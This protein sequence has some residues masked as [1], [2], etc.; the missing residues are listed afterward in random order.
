MKT[1]IQRNHTADTLKGLAV[2][3]M[4]QVHII[5]QF[6]SIA[7]N[8]SMYG[9]ISY[10][11]GGPFCAPVFIAVMGYFLAG[12]KQSFLYFL[13]R[14]IVL[15]L[16][17][18]LL[19]TGRSINLFIS[20]FQGKYDLDP[21]FFIFGA[22]ILT[23]AGLSIILIAFLR[24]ISLNNLYLYIPV[25]ILFAALGGFVNI[26]IE[27]QN[28]FSGFI[29]GNYEQSYFPLFPWFSYVLSGYI[30]KIIYNKYK[31]FFTPF[32]YIHWVVTGLLSLVI[33]YFAYYSFK[34]SNNLMSYYHHNFYFFLWVIGFMMLYILFINHI[35]KLLK[36]SIVIYYLSWTGKN[37]TII[38]I[39]QWLI[40]GNIATAIFRTQNILQS[41]LWFVGITLF[42][43]I[44][45]FI[46]LKLKGYYKRKNES[47]L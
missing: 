27:S 5:E 8:N 10:F 42:S 25:L 23:L 4:I 43:S 17:G 6:A 45:A 22:D 19:N 2:L 40:I 9:Q 39:I 31:G 36:N 34:I 44:L 41:V 18:I 21:L 38:Y 15:F 47:I 14:G 1:T 33:L 46:Y 24:L 26:N 32:T 29:I 11:L 20:I 13:K 37:V 30:F 7:T 3:F 28:Y 12:S 16:F 35:V